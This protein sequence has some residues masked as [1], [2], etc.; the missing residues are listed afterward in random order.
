MSTSFNRPP[1]EFIDKHMIANV[2]GVM[3][4]EY[5]QRKPGAV[6]SKTELSAFVA[7]L[8]DLEVLRLVR[9]HP[10]LRSLAA[11]MR[12]D[13]EVLRWAHALT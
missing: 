10:G 4:H 9:S 7:G 8:T 11:N 5:L 2:E 13:A 1:G 3:I 6:P 12:N